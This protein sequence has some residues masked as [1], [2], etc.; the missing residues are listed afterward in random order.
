MADKLFFGMAIQAVD[1]FDPPCMRNFFRLET[2]MAGNTFERT[3][4]GTYKPLCIDIQADL[5]AFSLHRERSLA[6]TENAIRVGLSSQPDRKEGKHKQ[7]SSDYRSH[8]Q[9]GATV[10]SAAWSVL[11]RSL[12]QSRSGSICMPRIRRIFC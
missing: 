2:F 8:V 1:A 5:Y 6:M 9:E 4:C 11:V 7:G 3:V 10:G 12:H